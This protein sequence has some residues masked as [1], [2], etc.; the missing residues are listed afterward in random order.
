MSKDTISTPKP[1][2]VADIVRKMRILRLCG[3]D[4]GNSYGRYVAQKER[5][6]LIVADYEERLRKRRK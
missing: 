3:I 4:L 6:D 1:D 2:S 5:Y